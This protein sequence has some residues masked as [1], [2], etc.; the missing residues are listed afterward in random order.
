MT[1]NYSV[2][3]RSSSAGQGRGADVAAVKTVPFIL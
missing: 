1:L 2:A 3:L